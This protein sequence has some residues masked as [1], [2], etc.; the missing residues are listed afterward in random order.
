[1][2]ALV[3]VAVLIA[4]WFSFS[5]GNYA[6]AGYSIYVLAFF[7]TLSVACALAISTRDRRLIGAAIVLAGNFFLSHYSWGTEDP[8]LSAIYLDLATAAYFILLGTRRFELTIGAV[9]LL[10][11]A[12]GVATYLGYIPPASERAPQ[13]IA[14]SHPDILAVLGHGCSILLGISAGDSGGGL[15]DHMVSPSMAAYYRRR[16][17]SGL[18]S[19][20]KD[21]ARQAKKSRIVE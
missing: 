17:V 1:M 12:A 5:A 4:T 3:F 9:M 15:R 2:T 10:S 14:W 20:A 13:F 16:S 18:H 21:I 11:V 6:Y 19:L 8:I 7:A